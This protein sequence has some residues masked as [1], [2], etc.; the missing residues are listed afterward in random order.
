MGNRMDE[1]KV[2]CIAEHIT[3]QRGGGVSRYAYQIVNS[4]RKIGG[5]R[6]NAMDYS[7]VPHPKFA[8]GFLDRHGHVEDF[9]YNSI[10]SRK[11]IA[12]ADGLVHQ[13]EPM[14]TDS[15]IDRM[16]RKV[17]VIT[18]MHDII[19]I[20]RPDVVAARNRLE[21]YFMIDVP[22]ARMRAA[23]RTSNYFIVNS[24]QTRDE[25]SKYNRLEG[26]N[27]DMKIKVINLG[28][29]DQFFKKVNRKP[30]KGF[31]V[32][33]IGAIS[34]RKNVD[35]MFKAFSI[36]SE[37]KAGRASE[38]RLY[39]RNYYGDLKL[40]KWTKFYG[41]APDSKLADIYDTFDVFI[42]PSMYEGFSIPIMQAQ[43]RGIPVI[44]FK[45]SL[46]PKEVR[47]HCIEA[48]DVGHMAELLARL[49]NEGYGEKARAASIRYA[50]HFTWENAANATLKVYEGF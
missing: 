1:G 19:P 9:I 37:E 36:L 32:G 49:K 38:M 23:I 34:Q 22:A 12:K 31:V 6:I 33:Y 50:G 2:L 3:A 39:G 7:S 26:M 4:I 28:I 35:A 25:I 16:R 47:L 27:P 42:W 48:R 21:K 20:L 18:T 11:A 14:L 40:P 29:D 24:T 44:I 43:A 5:I 8:S 41:F 13:L 17:K 46:I 15:A 10:F 45:D 30:H